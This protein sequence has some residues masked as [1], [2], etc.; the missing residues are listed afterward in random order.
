V[1]GVGIGRG[2]AC[3]RLRHYRPRSLEELSE[4]RPVTP[5]RIGTVATQGEI[6]LGGERGQQCDQSFRRG[7]SHLSAVATNECSPPLGAEWL[8]VSPGDQWGARRQLRNPDIVVVTSPD[9][10][11]P[12]A[13]GRTA[14]GA[15]ADSLIMPARHAKAD[16]VNGQTA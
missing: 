16:D 12:H 15:Q 14:H 11:L 5:G 7:P 2:A 8:R 9:I 6:L 4:H 3:L 10:F 13:A 1:P